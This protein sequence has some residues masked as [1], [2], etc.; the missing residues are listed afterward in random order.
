MVLE[1]IKSARHGS[2]ILDLSDVAQYDWHEGQML[3]VKQP[4]TRLRYVVLI[5]F[6]ST[7]QTIDP[8]DRIMLENYSGM[9]SVLRD[10]KRGVHL[11]EQLVWE[12]FGG[13]DRWDGI[14][15]P[16]PAT[17]PG[18]SDWITAK[19]LFAFTVSPTR[20]NHAP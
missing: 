16:R 14:C 1:Q 11:D 17:A 5:D 9:L 10:V 15:D 2:R 8:D 6:A 7:L 4:G 18:D 12:H 3:L 20:F 13:P 19:G